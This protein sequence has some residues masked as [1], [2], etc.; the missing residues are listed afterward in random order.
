MMR[1]ITFIMVVSVLGTKFY[2]AW[3]TKTPIVWDASDLA[4]I[5]GSYT[6]KLIQNS[7]EK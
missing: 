3:L 4:L 5:G 2:N 1:L 7:Q 6:A